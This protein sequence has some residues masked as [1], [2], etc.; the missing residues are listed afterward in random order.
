MWLGEVFPKAHTGTDY[1]A[2][3]GDTFDNT[4]LSRAKIHVVIIEFIL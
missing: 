4:S 1:G 3:C 2:G